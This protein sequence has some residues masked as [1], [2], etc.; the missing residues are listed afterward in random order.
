MKLKI[1]IDSD[2]AACQD[3]EDAIQL[4][5]MLIDRIRLGRTGTKV[6]D[7]NGNSVGTWELRIGGE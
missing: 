5:K 7:I 1:E 3:K 6:L 2:N 4:L